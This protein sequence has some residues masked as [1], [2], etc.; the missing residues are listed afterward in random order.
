MERQQQKCASNS[1]MQFCL[2]VNDVLVW[3]NSCFLFVLFLCQIF[4]IT[5]DNMVR[6]NFDSG[7]LKS[8]MLQ[9]LH[10]SG[11][12]ESRMLTV[13]YLNI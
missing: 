11:I 8:Q 13:E 1:S 9:N 10:E 6:L 7:I 4:F 12:L 3:N 2:L 5:V